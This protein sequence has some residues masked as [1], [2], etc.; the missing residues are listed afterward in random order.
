MKKSNVTATEAVHCHNDNV[1]WL[2]GISL[3]EYNE[4]APALRRSPV[5][6]QDSP[7]PC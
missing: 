5:C 2:Y 6:T 7:G 1:S 3:V 4:H